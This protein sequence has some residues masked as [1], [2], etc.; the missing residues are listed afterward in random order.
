VPGVAGGFLQQVHQHPAQAHW[1]PGVRAAA[2]LIEAGPGEGHRVDLLPRP[3]VGAGGCLQRA[4]RRLVAVRAGALPG[5][6]MQD[7]GDLGAGH[8]RDQPQQAGAAADG[9]PP[10]G[11]LIQA[12]GLAYQRFP[13]V[14]QQGVQG[15]RLAAGQPRRLVIGHHH[16]LRSRG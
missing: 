4:A 7:P 10:R 11:R 12:A 8:V 3:P 13:L 5:E 9:R 14:L 1:R 6:A 16:N 2:Q 15:L